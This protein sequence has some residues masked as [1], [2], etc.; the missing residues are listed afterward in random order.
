MNFVLTT[1]TYGP[2]R[3]NINLVTTT[4]LLPSA[5]HIDSWHH[6]TIETQTMARLTTAEHALSDN[7]C[8]ISTVV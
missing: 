4:H 6:I 2:E 8:R 1:K 3:V 7:S 5:E